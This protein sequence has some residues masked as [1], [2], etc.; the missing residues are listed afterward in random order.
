MKIRT[1]LEERTLELLWHVNILQEFP[2]AGWTG[3]LVLGVLLTAS[4]PVTIKTVS[5]FYRKPKSDAPKKGQ[6]Y[7]KLHFNRQKPWA[8]PGRASFFKVFARKAKQTSK[9]SFQK[10]KM[11][12]PERSAN[13]QSTTQARWEGSAR[14]QT[15]HLAK[16]EQTKTWQ[17]WH[18]FPTKELG[19]W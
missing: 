18:S 2:S 12:T 3:P 7:E 11:T 19:W 6:W 13:T 5:G 10:P 4:S 16:T 9:T 1:I 8:G 17:L 14:G 15:L